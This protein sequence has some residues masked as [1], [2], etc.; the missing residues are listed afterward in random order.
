MQNKILKRRRNRHV[1]TRINKRDTQI[2]VDNLNVGFKLKQ[3]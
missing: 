2:E 3:A 1:N